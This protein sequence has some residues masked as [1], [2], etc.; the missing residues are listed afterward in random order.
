MPKS[1]VA[2]LSAW[3]AFALLPALLAPQP[4]AAARPATPAAITSV[5]ASPGPRTGQITLRWSSTGRNTSGFRLVTALNTFGRSSS[6]GPSGGRRSRVTYFSGRQRS[7]TL[8][9][10]KVY[11]LGAGVAS[12]NALFFRLYAVNTAGSGMAVRAYPYQRAVLPRPAAPKAKGTP[13]RVATFNVRTS[14]ATQDKHSWNQRVNKVARQI[15]YQHPGVVALQ[16]LGP[17][18][19]DGKKGTTKGNPRQTTSLLTALAR[20]G[21]GRYRLVRTT[22]YVAPGVPSGTQGGR[23]LY[24]SNRYSLINRCPESTGGRSYS[25]AC[26]LTLPILSSDSG[27]DKRRG[28]IAHFRD[29][30]TGKRFWVVSVHLDHRHSGNAATERKYDALRYRQAN[31]AAGAVAYH[32]RSKDPVIIGGDFNSWQNNRVGYSPHDR[33]VR[34]GYYD[35]SAATRRVNFRYTT[36]NGFKTRIPLS[37]HGVGVRLD[38]LYV[39]RAW[40]T[41]RYENVMKVTDSLRP[42]DHNMVLVD[43]VL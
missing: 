23:I 3:S 18:R 5:S 14:Y 6:A 42:S 1:T 15:V 24:D 12:G 33:L 36:F 8:S 43:T 16:E 34:L 39:K 11:S 7:A 26:S 2:V 27:K 13:I 20:N 4:A 22:P 41:A 9:A 38:H 28:A 32:N 19:A 37:A 30:R 35:T 17:G 25:N 31:Y 29:R 40:G 21:G 10:S